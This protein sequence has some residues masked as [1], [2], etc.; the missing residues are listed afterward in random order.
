MLQ[1]M[2]W[3]KKIS[4]MIKGNNGSE[5]QI[6]SFYEQADNKQKLYDEV[7]NEKLFNQLIEYAKIKVVEQS[8]NELR[9]Q[10]ANN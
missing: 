2:K 8:T 3:V 4:E 9:K 1:R 5:K 7:L 6:K 10:H